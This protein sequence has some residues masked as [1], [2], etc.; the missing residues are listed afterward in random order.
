MRLGID[1]G[2]TR[3]VVAAADRGNY[4]VIAFENVDG[5]MIE[6]IPSMS[7]LVDGELIHGFAAMRA[8]LDDRA[9]CI[10]SWKRLLTAHG[11]GHSVRI[12]ERDITL[13]E[14]ATSFL[15]HVREQ[16]ATASNL[17]GKKSVVPSVVVSVPANAHSSQRFTTLEAFRAAGFEVGA[18]LNEPSAAGLEYAH[19]HRGTLNKKRDHV[20]IYDLGGG[21]F[22]AALVMVA[23]GHHDVIDTTGIH[24]LGGDDFDRVLLDMALET[25]GIDA[26]DVHGSLP[27]L[28]V[29]CRRAKEQIAPNSKRV[30]VDLEDYGVPVE[31]LL[32][33]IAA[34]YERLR[35]LVARSMASLGVVLSAGGATAADVDDL[36]RRAADAGVAG[37]YIVGGASA[38]PLVPRMLRE[39]LGRRV[40]RSPHPSG[41]I[42]IGLA[43]AA[44]SGGRARVGQRLSRHLGVFR[45]ADHGEQVAFDRI[46]ARGTPTP[47]V[48]T[49][50]YRAAHNVGHFRFVECG[51]VSGG[52]HPAGD[53]SPHA[54][55]R[56]P[57]AA[58]AR[59][60]TPIEEIGVERTESG[61]QV[62]E[63][64]EVDASGVVSV[65]IRADDGFEQRFVLS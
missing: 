58:S 16:L 27:Q 34:Y 51:S 54:D 49:R 31:P 6:H 26:D 41:A 40:H 15:V 63:R 7:A 57:F 32:I 62:T 14:L 33:D 9:P 10:G 2:T 44:D 38:L 29:A 25:L 56:F 23:D 39:E 22:D 61:P 19:R 28:L 1:L 35:P 64:Y 36:K 65:T 5:D 12:G 11:P 8:A 50:Q 30:I 20:A 13:L 55:V 42:A 21:T 17:T 3:T 4:P 52:G 37:V 43:I 46:F 24:R 60:G 47:A 48:E 45:E 18:M 59:N 53:I